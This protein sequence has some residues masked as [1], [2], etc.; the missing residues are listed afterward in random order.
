[1]YSESHAGH[2]THACHYAAETTTA[3]PIPGQILTHGLL[4]RAF[5]A[6]SDGGYEVPL[7]PSD[8]DNS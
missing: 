2:P 6:S 7:I 3:A 1:M 8:T 4:T 5:G